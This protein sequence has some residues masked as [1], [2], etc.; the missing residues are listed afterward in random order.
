MKIISTKDLGNFIRDRR[1]TLGYTQAYISKFT[2]LSA[3]FI[4]NLENGKETA[5]LGK[6]LFLMNTLGIDLEARNRDE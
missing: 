6:A 4:S 1:K 3:S 5:D 2:G